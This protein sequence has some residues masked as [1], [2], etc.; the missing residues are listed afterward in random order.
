V[1]RAVAVIR[2]SLTTLNMVK[3]SL[4][5]ITNL[6]GKEGSVQVLSVSGTLKALFSSA[7]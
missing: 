7:K 5:A 6:A 2:V 1:D 4:A 3:A